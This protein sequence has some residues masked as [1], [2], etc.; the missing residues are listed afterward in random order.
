VAHI[1]LVLVNLGEN[2]H[3]NLVV[4]LVGSLLAHSNSHHGCENL[5]MVD[6]SIASN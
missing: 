4:Q 3:L 1:H 2:L 6:F 5:C